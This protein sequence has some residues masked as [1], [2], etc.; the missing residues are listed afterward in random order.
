M[1]VDSDSVVSVS[2]AK[3]GV[4]AKR[5]APRNAAN[6]DTSLLPRAYKM[7]TD[8][9]PARKDTIWAARTPSRTRGRKSAIAAG[10]PIG[11][12]PDEGALPNIDAA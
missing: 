9:M 6:R 2:L 10:Y 7:S 11:K 3:R 12:A 5:S 1:N 8:P 4:E